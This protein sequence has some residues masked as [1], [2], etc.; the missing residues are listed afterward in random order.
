MRP[1]RIEPGPGQE[2]V[3]DYPRPPSLGPAGRRVRV[4][5]DGEVIADSID[6]LKV[7]ETSGPP[8]YYVPVKDIRFDRLKPA[9]HASYCEWKG[10]ARYYDIVT[11]RRRSRRAAWYYPR[12]KSDYAA[13]KNHVAFY[14][15]R[16]DEALLDDERA[17]PQPGDFY[18]GWITSN[19][20]GPFKGEPGSQSW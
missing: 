15:G 12:P 20:V 6:A 16:V 9:R 4:L 17:R 2:S 18:G 5:F 8:T 11:G 14:A 3:W 10:G 13:L 1:Q 7:C 19:I